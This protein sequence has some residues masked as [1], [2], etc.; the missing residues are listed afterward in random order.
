[1]SRSPRITGSELL[2]ALTRAG[3]TVV[4]I[5]GSHHFLRHDD[6]RITVVPIHSGDTVGQGLLH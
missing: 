6:G 5:K 4:R 3:F 1:M 2:A